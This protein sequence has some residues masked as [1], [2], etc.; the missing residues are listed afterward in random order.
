MAMPIRRIGMLGDHMQ[1]VNVAHER[2]IVLGLKPGKL[3]TCSSCQC[4]EFLRCRLWDRRG[5]NR[6]HL[7][8]PFE[9]FGDE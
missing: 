3:G 5:R 2:R 4:H 9:S 1:V 7:R 8:L 6:G